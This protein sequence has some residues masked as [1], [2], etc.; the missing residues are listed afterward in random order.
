MQ[1]KLYKAGCKWHMGGTHVYSN[2]TFIFV[3]NNIMTWTNNPESYK[4]Y[5]LPEVTVDEILNMTI[6]HVSPRS[7]VTLLE[8]LLSVL[9]REDGRYSGMCM[10]IRD[11]E[12]QHTIKPCEESRLLAL[13]N[14]KGN[15]PYC[16]IYIIS[17]HLTQNLALNMLKILL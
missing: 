7:D 8:M 1:K 14:N 13:I 10:A 11:M 17:N 2:I 3:E 15:H 4:N 6:E 12:M 5:D 16:G 9:K